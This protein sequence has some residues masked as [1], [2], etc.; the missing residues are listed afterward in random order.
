MLLHL[1]SGDYFTVNGVGL[2]IWELADGS[3]SEERIAADLARRFE[4]SADAAL[5]DVRSYCR[6]LEKAGLMDRGPK[7]ANKPVPRKRG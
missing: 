2:R 3:R 6:S 4:V 5:Q 1:K 7:P